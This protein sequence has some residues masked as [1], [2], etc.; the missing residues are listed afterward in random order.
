MEKLELI[1]DQVEQD[2]QSLAAGEHVSGPSVDEYRTRVE[3]TGSFA[4]RV[5]TSVG[6]AER[7]LEQGSRD[8]SRARHDLRM[9]RGHSRL[10]QGQARAWAAGR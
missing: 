7:L 5:V 4:G 9:A 6:S 3:R 10:P 2:S 1:I 8:P